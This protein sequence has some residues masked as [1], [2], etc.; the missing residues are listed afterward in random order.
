MWILLGLQSDKTR[1]EEVSIRYPSISFRKYELSYGCFVSSEIIPK[2]HENNKNA[3]DKIENPLVD[4]GI[5]LEKKFILLN[6]YIIEI[7]LVKRTMCFLFPV[8][9]V[10]YSIINL[11]IKFQFGS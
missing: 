2:F 7:C 4:L 8:Y 9:R 3:K 11:E 10:S 5:S 1:L 6:L